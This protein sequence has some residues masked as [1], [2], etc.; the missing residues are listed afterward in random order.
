MKQF[1][2]LIYE[3]DPNWVKSFN[4]NLEPRLKISGI[5]L[6]LY[7][8]LD[9]A[10]VIQDIEWLPNL[11]LVDY[12]LGTETGKDIIE[13]ILD[14]P[15]FQRTSI[16][17]YSGGESIESLKSIIDELECGVSCYLKDGEE[18]LNAVLEKA[19]FNL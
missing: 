6:L 3:D 9:S 14:D 7:H 15:Q 5:D 11:I 10:T 16:F 1:R 2:V 13:N 12:D 4:F 17:L 18:L 19:N 8:R